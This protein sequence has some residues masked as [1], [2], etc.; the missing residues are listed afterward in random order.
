MIPLLYVDSGLLNWFLLLFA[1]FLLLYAIFI[2]LRFVSF[3]ISVATTAF[4]RLLAL[5]GLG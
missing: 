3:L 1:A 4:G 2:L 5:I